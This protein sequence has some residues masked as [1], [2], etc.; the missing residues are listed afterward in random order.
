LIRQG[1]SKTKRGILSA[2]LSFPIQ[3]YS[4]SI[5]D[6]LVPGHRSS[7]GLAEHHQSCRATGC[8]ACEFER[9]EIEGN[10]RKREG[11][12][13]L[14]WLVHAKEREKMSTKGELDCES[15]VA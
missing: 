1:V 10:R 3:F 15:P 4:A 5:L 6:P 7:M 13:V 14:G 2:K 9:I 11:E 12:I 8:R